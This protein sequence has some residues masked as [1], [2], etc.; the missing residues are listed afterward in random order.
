MKCQRIPVISLFLL[1]L[2]FNTATAE[3]ETPSRVNP[4]ELPKGIYSKG[5]IPE[6]LPQ[7]LTLQAIFTINERKIVTISGENFVLGDFAFGKRVVSIS[8]DRVTLD[9]GGKEEIL[10]LESS[11]FILQKNSQK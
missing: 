4:F 3:D 10:L 6:E 9:A 7:N 5:N 2:S 11:K 8:K 1:L